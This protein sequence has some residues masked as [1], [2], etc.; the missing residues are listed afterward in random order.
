ERCR[1]GEA[2]IRVGPGEDALQVA[3]A[4]GAA[5]GVVDADEVVAHLMDA[6]GRRRISAVG[7]VLAVDVDVSTPLAVPVAV[8]AEVEA[9]AEVKSGIAERG[10]RERPRRAV[11]HGALE[12]GA[13]EAA[14]V[15]AHLSVRDERGEW[16]AP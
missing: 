14:V 6:P 4:G 11:G 12:H 7:D 8:E 15:V 13:N 1:L 9:G 2:D 10:D 16:L 3:V 5:D